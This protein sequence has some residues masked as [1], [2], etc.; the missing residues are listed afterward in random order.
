M[1]RGAIGRRYKDLWGAPPAADKT[2]VATGKARSG[3]VHAAMA[4]EA[5]MASVDQETTV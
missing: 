3:G 2:P 1:I 5:F 4:S